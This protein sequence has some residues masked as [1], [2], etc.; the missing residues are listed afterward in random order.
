MGWDARGHGR[1]GIGTAEGPTLGNMRAAYTGFTFSLSAGLGMNSVFCSIGPCSGVYLQSAY[2]RNESFMFLCDHCVLHPPQ[3][4]VP[5]ANDSRLGACGAGYVRRGRCWDQFPQWPP[6]PLSSF[7]EHADNTGSAPRSRLLHS[8][9]TSHT[10][11]P[12]PFSP[13]SRPATP[14]ARPF[15]LLPPRRRTF[16]CSSG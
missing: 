2:K 10:P 1:I 9:E 11:R 7:G 4:R 8:I 13:L 12:T 14:Y 5:F 6:T 3:R 16:Y 15:P